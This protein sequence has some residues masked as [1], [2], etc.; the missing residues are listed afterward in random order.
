MIKAPEIGF[1]TNG[2]SETSALQ[3]ANSASVKC[4]FEIFQG[5]AGLIA[6]RDEWKKI[7]QALR[8]PRFFQCYE[9]YESY[10]DT[11]SEA[12][13]SVY[14]VLARQQSSPAG[15]IPLARATQ[16]IAGIG[17]R[18]LELIQHPHLSLSD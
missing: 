5:R 17:I 14:F 18:S 11:L 2:S 6:I 8:A 1:Y 4:Q 10:M 13:N 3:T 7:T 12:D 16:K 15:I 9:W